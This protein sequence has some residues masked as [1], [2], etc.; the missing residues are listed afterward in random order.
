MRRRN[1]SSLVGELINEDKIILGG[2]ECAGMSVKGHY[3]KKD[4]V[5]ARL[6]SAKAEAT[7]GAS[8]N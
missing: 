6:L 2:Q 3:P 4:G 1:S 5:I 8:L 7:P